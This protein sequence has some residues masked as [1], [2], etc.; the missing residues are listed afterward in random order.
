M[1]ETLEGEDKETCIMAYQHL[2]LVVKKSVQPEDEM[3]RVIIQAWPAT[4]LPG[5]MRLLKEHN[6][7]ALSLLAMW[8][9]ILREGN[10][11][12]R[13][14]KGW[15]IEAL[16]LMRKNREKSGDN[17]DDVWWGTIDWIAGLIRED[18]DFLEKVTKEEMT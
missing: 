2:Y 4:L 16:W 8:A 14:W 3:N 15:I 1:T 13:G 17:V 5:F 7:P 6:P 11:L 10:W 12:S 9:I 18:P